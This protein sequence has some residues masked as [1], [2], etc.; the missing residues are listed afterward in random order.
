MRKSLL[1]TIENKVYW[2]IVG[3]ILTIAFGAMGLYTYFHEQKPNLLFEVINESNVLDVHK[4][5]ENLTI[6]FDNENIQ[7]KNLNLRIITIKISNNGEVDILQ[8]YYDQKILW[9]FN[10]DKGKI[11]NDARVVN[12]N[13]DYL[14]NNISP[15]IVDNKTVELEKVIFE[16]GKYFS[17]EILVIH[18]KDT[19][20]VIS[21]VGKI[22]GIES[23]TPIKTWEEDLEQKLLEELFYG[24]F[25]VNALRPII[26]LFV[27][28]LLIVFIV[29]TSDW[30]GTLKRKSKI[31]S[32]KRDV[33]RYFENELEDEKTK[34]IADSYIIGGFDEIERIEQLINNPDELK[35]K[36]KR[37]NLENEYREKI[38]EAIGIAE[39][40]DVMNE[41]SETVLY[42]S[43]YSTIIDSRFWHGPSVKTLLE[44]N[45]IKM[46]DQDELIID[47]KFE[48]TIKNM[49]KKFTAQRNHREAKTVKV[50]GKQ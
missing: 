16:K 18:K 49:A 23:V 25:L 43:H 10:V 33:R 39:D 47:Q 3:V 20:P 36:I 29:I 41:E 26:Y 37:I 8:S 19:L 27:F 45:I 28:I 21:Y 1:E 34:I 12:T 9:G 11:I 38:K 46:N 4:S 5:L 42:G 50:K 30:I 22:V 14:K 24:G 2:G 44:N 31:K 35:I 40:D 48:D 15:R 13:S 7:K 6:Y 17:I 32:R